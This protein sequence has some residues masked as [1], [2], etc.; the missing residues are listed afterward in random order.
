[1]STRVYAH[2]T[3]PAVIRTYASDFNIADYSEPTNLEDIALLDAQPQNVYLVVDVSS[4]PITLDDMIKVANIMGRTETGKR[5]Y[6]H[7]NVIENIM[8]VKQRM[9]ELGAQ[10][11]KASTM[12][13]IQLSTFPSLETALDYIQ[14]QQGV[15]K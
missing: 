6:H 11:L 1:M 13:S 4:L 12:G 5:K 14:Q 10:N 2:P 7:P 9:V 8:I 15:S 3:L